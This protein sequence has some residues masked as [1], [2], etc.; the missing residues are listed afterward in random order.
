MI[1][2]RQCT[3]RLHTDFNFMIDEDRL[4]GCLDSAEFFF[5]EDLKEGGRVRLFDG[6][7]YECSGDITKVDMTIRMIEVRPDWSTWTSKRKLL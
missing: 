3:P 4:W 7:G 2:K 1:I 5:H 6:L